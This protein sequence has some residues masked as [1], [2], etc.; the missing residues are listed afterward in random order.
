MCWQHTDTYIFLITETITD[1]IT[2]ADTDILVYVLVQADTHNSTSTDTITD[3][4]ADVVVFYSRNIMMAC[5]TTESVTG[6]YGQ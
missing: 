1:K 3:T 6:Q 4:G 2:D 5:V